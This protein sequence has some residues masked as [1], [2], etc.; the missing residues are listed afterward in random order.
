MPIRPTS[1]PLRPPKAP[2]PF[3]RVGKV[4]QTV[5]L[6]GPEKSALRE[7]AYLRSGGFC[8]IHLKEGCS[9][10]VP[11]LHGHLSH[12]RGVGAGGSDVEENVVWSCANCHSKSHNCGGKPCPEKPK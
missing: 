3:R 11:W 6:A 10:F 2:K 4:L 7:K 12:V 5:R 8:E 1:N 9:G